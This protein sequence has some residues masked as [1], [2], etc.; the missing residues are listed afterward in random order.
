MATTARTG[1][2]EPAELFRLTVWAAGALSIFFWASGSISAKY[3]FPYAEPLTFHAARLAVA[4]AILVPLALLWRLRALGHA[5]VAGVV[6][7]SR[8][9]P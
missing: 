9:G 3:G 5:T 7:A 6:L 1:S 2:V 4:V 8:A